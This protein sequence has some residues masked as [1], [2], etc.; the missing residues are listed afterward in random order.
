[1]SSI[2]LEIRPQGALSAF[3][4]L[5]PSANYSGEWSGLVWQ[6]F[7]DSNGLLAH[8]YCQQR[9]VTSDPKSL[10]SNKKGA[11][12]PLLSSEGCHT[13]RDGQHCPLITYQ[14]VFLRGE[15]PCN[16]INSQLFLMN[17]KGLWQYFRNS[18]SSYCYPIQHFLLSHL[19]KFTIGHLS[20]ATRG[21]KESTKYWACKGGFLKRLG[22]LAQLHVHHF[23]P[24][25][26]SP[27]PVLGQAEHLPVQLK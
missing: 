19:W 1:M 17:K 10:N 15:K 5:L 3:R 6:P 22:I 2:G 25:L 14:G 7:A 18:E 26:V 4:P 13:Q 24:Q 27:V 9:A 8:H 21:H 11:K 20:L 12:L 16:D 23:P